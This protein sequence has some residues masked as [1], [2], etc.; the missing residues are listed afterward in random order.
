MIE[1]RIALDQQES[2]ERVHLLLAKIGG[3]RV[4]DQSEGTGEGALDDA[5]HND[6]RALQFLPQ[7][8]RNAL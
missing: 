5:A 1:E 7:H 4:G 3:H 2:L 6:R 8:P